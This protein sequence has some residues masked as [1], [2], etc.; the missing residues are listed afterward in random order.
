MNTLIEK[1]RSPLSFA[2]K[3]ISE[4]DINTLFEAARW[5]ASSYNEQPWRFIYATKGQPLYDDLLDCLM[6]ANQSWSR[7]APLLVLTLASSTFARNGKVNRHAWH[8]VGLAVGN[9]SVQATELDLYLHQMAGFNAEKARENF[10]VPDGFDPVSVIAVGY[11]GDGS[12]LDE[13]Q[14]QRESNPRIRKPLEE[15]V[16]NRKW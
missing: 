16:F 9:F 8:D 12:N 3:A 15:I 7:H 2:D 5:A 11:L 13:S 4:A 1:R 14:K 10:N 6:E